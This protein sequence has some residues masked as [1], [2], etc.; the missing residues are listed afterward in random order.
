MDRR[1]EKMKNKNLLRIVCLIGFSC[2]F[3]FVGFGQKDI[4]WKDAHNYYGQLLTVE[5]AIVATFNSGRACFLNFHQDY[6]RYFSAV[7]FAADFNKF[8]NAPQDFY[9]NKTVRVTGVIK[10]YQGKPEIILNDP[11]NI[12]I[13]GE[14][15]KQEEILEISWEDA[16]KYCGKYCCVNGKIVATFNSG[17]AC[18]LNFHKNWKRY[19]TAVIFASDYHK[20]PSSPELYYNNKQVKVKGIIQEYQGK[21]EIILEIPSQ[22]EIGK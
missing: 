11:V 22:I 20:F 19:F 3:N 1:I 18:F 6:K 8:P 2:G 14:L 10:E 21:P 15:R 16:D 17:K 13:I 4:S 7:I 9:L 12:K 5:G